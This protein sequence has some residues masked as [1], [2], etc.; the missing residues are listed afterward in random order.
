VCVCVCE[1]GLLV[2]QVHGRWGVGVGVFA[3]HSHTPK[4]PEL[5]RSRIN[6]TPWLYFGARSLRI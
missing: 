4:K 2:Q 5:T 3:P 1:M 6:N